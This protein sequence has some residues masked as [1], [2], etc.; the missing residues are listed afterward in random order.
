MKK[1]HLPLAI[2]FYSLG[3]PRVCTAYRIIGTG[4]FTGVNFRVHHYM[5]ITKIIREPNFLATHSQF[6]TKNQLFRT[7]LTLRVD[8]CTD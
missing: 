6:Y 4:I 3:F 1:P 5:C 8:L 2:N 7:E